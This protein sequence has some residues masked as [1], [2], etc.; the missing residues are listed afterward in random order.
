MKRRTLLSSTIATLAFGGSRLGSS[1]EARD[2]VD[3][4]IDP[5]NQPSDLLASRFVRFPK[6]D[7]ES[8]QDFTRGISSFLREDGSS[9]EAFEHTEAFLKSK[10]LQRK[11]I[12]GGN[13]IAG[14]G[15]VRSFFVAM[16]FTVP[17]AHLQKS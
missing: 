11:S 5:W 6:Q 15:G 7:D 14:N 9:K 13:F 8:R 10:G 17:H 2:F 4:K 12:F 16:C 3:V 1:A